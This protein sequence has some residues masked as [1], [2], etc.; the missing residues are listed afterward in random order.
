ML[1]VHSC[2]VVTRPSYE[3]HVSK[4]QTNQVQA[5]KGDNL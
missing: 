2:A 5:A 4:T 1:P 3:N